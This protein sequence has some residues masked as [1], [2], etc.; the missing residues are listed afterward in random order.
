MERLN[1]QQME[2]K[3]ELKHIAPYLP[4]DIKIFDENRRAMN[5]NYAIMNTHGGTN[6]EAAYNVIN[7]NMKIILRPLSDLTKTLFQFEYGEPTTLED[8][9]NGN[10]DLGTDRWIL[11]D[12]AKE[13]RQERIMDLPYFV[14]EYLFQYHF[15][16]FGLIEKGLAIDINTIEDVQTKI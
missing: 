4:Y 11:Q 5:M 7:Y 9:I 3:L 14:A 13:Q 1:P 8:W 16:V 10:C 2:N 12:K 15:D 6:Y